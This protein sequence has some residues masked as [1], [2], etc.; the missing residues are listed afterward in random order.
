MLIQLAHTLTK[1]WD[2][3]IDEVISLTP[4]WYIAGKVIDINTDP[5]AKELGDIVGNEEWDWEWRRCRVPIA[6]LNPNSNEDLLDPNRLEL[7]R[8]LLHPLPIIVG[9]EG[10]RPVV[11]DGWHR[12]KAAQEKGETTTDALV[13]NPTSHSSPSS[14]FSINGG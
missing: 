4:Q 1:Y 14:S 6:V 3:K 9:L 2:M 12:L 8:N 11:Y 13:G 10:N 5:I 7:A